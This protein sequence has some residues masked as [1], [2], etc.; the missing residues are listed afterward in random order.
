MN[1]FFFKLRTETYK[2]LSE[3]KYPPGVLFFNYI[4]ILS[5]PI[6]K[7]LIMFVFIYIF[8]IIFLNQVKQ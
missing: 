5:Y 8:L 3:W 4:F 6:I 7:Y 2:H 1:N